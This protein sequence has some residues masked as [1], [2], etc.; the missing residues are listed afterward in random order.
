MKEFDENK[1]K[2]LLGTNSYSYIVKEIFDKIQKAEAD[3]LEGTE[4]LREMYANLN[5]S[6]TPMLDL[7][8]FVTGAEKIAGND[9]K[10]ADI[11]G[12][13]TKK[14]KTGYDLNF[15]I[16]LCKEEHFKNLSRDGHPDPKSTIKSIETEFDKPGT[17]IEE[18]IKSGLFDCLKSD[19]LGKIKNNLQNNEPERIDKLNESYIA[20]GVYQYNP[21]GIKLDHPEKIVMLTESEVL[22]FDKEKNT[23]VRLNESEIAIPAEHAR[24]MTAINS[25]PYNPVNGTFSLNES[26]DFKLNLMNNG[27]VM[28]NDKPIKKSDVKTFLLESVGVYTNDPTKVQNFN[29]INYLRDADNF[30]ALMENS[31]KLVKISELTVMKNLNESYIMFAKDD[32]NGNCPKIIS[33]SKEGLGNKL[34]ESFNDMV[35]TINEVLETPITNLFESQLINE[36]KLIDERNEKIVSL[37]ESQKQINEKLVKI[38]TLKKMADE[39]SP[40]MDKLNEQEKKLNDKLAENIGHLNFYKN[41][42]KLY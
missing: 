23:F 17:V 26:W 42:F 27:T 7:K 36:Q 38:G 14:V 30:I 33:A 2:E 31:S 18:G 32:I 13:I 1:K 40:A 35:Q 4:I 3:T 37:N 5:E 9:T 22:E 8:P 41:E 19:L 24:L 34:F 16:N 21:I 25:C 6:I 39:N 11:L 28:V 20:D 12:F 29:K 15:L 10:L